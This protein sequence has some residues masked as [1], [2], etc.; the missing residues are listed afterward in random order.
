M[1]NLVRGL[2]GVSLFMGFTIAPARSDEKAK[3]Q[4]PPPKPQELKVLN[5]FLGTWDTD[6]V[7]KKSEW[8]PKEVNSKGMSKFE[9]MLDGR[10]MSSQSKSTG[11]DKVESFQ[12]MTYH[13]GDKKFFLWFFDSNGMVSEAQ[14]QWD[15]DNQ[16]LTWK[17]DIDENLASTNQVRFTD[18]ETIDWTMMVKDKT[19][20]VY[21]DLRGKMKRR[22]KEE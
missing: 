16:I 3:E 5:R 22:K 4:V 8:T 1:S 12:L 9:W 14:G 21:L 20:K 18:R 7:A 11:P 15:A 13:P 10:F 19:G 6:M 17:S 2:L